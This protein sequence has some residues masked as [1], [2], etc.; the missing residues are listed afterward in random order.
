MNRFNEKVM[1]D[2]EERLNVL[3]LESDKEIAKRLVEK[4]RYVEGIGDVLYAPGFQ[5]P[6]NLLL[7]NQIDILI[8]GAQPTEENLIKLN[9]IRAVCKPFFLVVL[10][11]KITSE[12]AKTY[13]YLSVDFYVDRDE[14]FEKTVQIF[15]ESAK[16]L[17]K[18]RA[19]TSENRKILLN[20]QEACEV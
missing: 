3:I 9:E 20:N 10:L 8:C 4:L 7:T 14:D 17:G 18:M 15:V 19:A 5:K 13:P 16:N 11:D 6:V 2:T 1:V 12:Y